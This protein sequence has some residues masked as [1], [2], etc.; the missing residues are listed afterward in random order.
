MATRYDPEALA[1][2]VAPA[3]GAA[4]LAARAARVATTLGSLA[5]AIAADAATGSLESNAPLRARALRDA[6]A[7]LGPAFV[8]VGQ[9]LSARPDLLPKPYL[10]AL[11]ELQDSLDPFPTPL[12]LAMLEEELGLNGTSIRSV[13]SSI[14]PEPVAA[15]S[16]GQV[17]KAT[18]ASTG[19]SVA[20]KVQ[21]PGIAATLA[22]DMVLL[23]RLARAV[24]TK[25]RGE[26]RKR[27]EEREREREEDEEGTKERRKTKE[28]SLKK[29]TLFQLFLGPRPPRAHRRKQRRGLTRRFHH[30]PA[31]SPARG[32]V[33]F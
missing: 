27:E 26:D 20:V 30:R 29:K 9:T 14:S 16:L 33:R 24:D 1:A 31:L 13:F 23:R 18:L 21:R 11:S 5:A 19:E 8:K 2:G 25:V 7:S 6:L 32:R 28:N 3:R 15:A 12:A 17:Y 10:D 22:V 4:A